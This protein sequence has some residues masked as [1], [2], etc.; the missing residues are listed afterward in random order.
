MYVCVCVRVYSC[1]CVHAYSHTNAHTHTHTH[2]HT[3]H[4][5]A[6][7]HTLVQ[8]LR[9]RRW[10][11]AFAPGL[12]ESLL[13]LSCLIRQI[14][15]SFDRIL[16]SFRICGSFFFKESLQLNTWNT[17]VFWSLLSGGAHWGWCLACTG[18][19]LNMPNIGLFWSNVRLFW[20]NTGFFWL[21]KEALWIVYRSAFSGCGE[22]RA[23]LAD[24]FVMSRLVLNNALYD[25]VCMSRVV[26]VR[27]LF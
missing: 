20:S 5:H 17:G 18:P 23:D 3:Q 21:N 11:K 8:V 26:H 12:Q 16:G 19:L 22:W 4:T 1:V 10:T 24:R 15:G 14:Q 13:L 9:Q 27:E 25:C 7:T 6:N 2:T